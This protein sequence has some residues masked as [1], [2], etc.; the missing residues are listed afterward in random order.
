MTTNAQSSDAPKPAR[1]K[2]IA[3]CAAMFFM[4]AVILAG[5]LFALQRFGL[6]YLKAIPMPGNAPVIWWRVDENAALVGLSDLI[7]ALV[8]VA[9]YCWLRKTRFVDLGFN[10]G[11]TLVAW[12]LVAAGEAWLVYSNIHGGPVSRVP[13]VLGPYALIAA[14]IAGPCAALAE[15]TFFRGFLMEVLRRGGLGVVWQILI[16]GFLFGL[17][18]VGYAGLDWTT[19]VSTALLGMFWSLVYVLAK[20]SLWPT[21]VAHIINDAVVIPSVYYLMVVMRSPH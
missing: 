5:L 1:G 2:A 19:M 3:V 10:R 11:G 18:H 8:P 21:I 20:R 7:A 6:P 15:E 13:G 9:L 17:A 16:S 14:A 4:Y 12:L